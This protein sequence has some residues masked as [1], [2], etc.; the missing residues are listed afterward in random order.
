MMDKEHQACHFKFYPISLKDIID[1]TLQTMFSFH[2][3]NKSWAYFTN[4]S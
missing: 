2:D 1:I 4:D 3:K